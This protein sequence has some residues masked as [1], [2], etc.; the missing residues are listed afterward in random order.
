MAPSLAHL[1]FPW[2]LSLS[3]SRLHFILQGLSTKPGLLLA[4]ILLH[5]LPSQEVEAARP[6]NGYSQNC[7]SIKPPYAIDQ[8]HDTVCPDF[9]AMGREILPLEVNEECMGQ[10]ILL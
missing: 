5:W 8:S 2:P 3:F 7:L 10:E 6:G 4:V 9:K 1:V